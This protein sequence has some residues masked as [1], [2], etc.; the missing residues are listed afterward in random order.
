MTVAAREQFLSGSPRLSNMVSK[1]LMS[2]SDGR[3]L[4]I[5]YEVMPDRDI[6][7]SPQRLPEGNLRVSFFTLL[8]LELFQKGGPCAA[9]GSGSHRGQESD[10]CGAALELSRIQGFQDRSAAFP[11]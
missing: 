1:R 7:V 2:C 3:R 9:V 4:A 10:L 8:G 5:T 11:P 6:R